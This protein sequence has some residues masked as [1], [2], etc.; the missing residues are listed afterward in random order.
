MADMLE[1]PARG[2]VNSAGAAIQD[3]QRVPAARSSR[4]A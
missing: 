1:P 3:Q 4:R 2:L